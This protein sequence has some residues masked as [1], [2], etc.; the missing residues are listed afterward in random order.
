MTFTRIQRIKSRI[1]IK[2]KCAA[3][4][5][6]LAIAGEPSSESIHNKRSLQTANSLPD[7]S[8]LDMVRNADTRTE[9]T[10]FE[11][12]RDISAIRRKYVVPIMKLE[13]V[14]MEFAAHLYMTK[15]VLPT[16]KLFSAME[17]RLERTRENIRTY[18]HL[19]MPLK[20]CLQAPSYPSA[21]LA[22]QP[23]CW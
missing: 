16:Q 20:R 10:S 5:K 4:G 7:L 8:S 13:P 12:S 14:P 19:L 6:R 17:K 1:S 18:K 11:L 9:K 22:L 15:K 23:C 3:T 2:L 21:H